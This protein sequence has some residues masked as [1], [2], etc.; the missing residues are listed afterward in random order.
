M[1]IA[2]NEQKVMEKEHFYNGD[3]TIELRASIG[4]GKPKTEGSRVLTS[5]R[6]TVPAGASI[7]N[8]IHKGAEELYVVISG[9]GLHTTEGEAYE[10]SQ[11]D[12]INTQSGLEHSLSTTGDDPMVLQASLIEAK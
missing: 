10:I 3:G 2:V 6:I 12:V 11:G 9:K 8:H 5:M 4:F 7:G 1:H